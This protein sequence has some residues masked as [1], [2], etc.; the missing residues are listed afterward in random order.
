MNVLLGQETSQRFVDPFEAPGHKN[1]ENLIFTLENIYCDT[2]NFDTFVSDYPVFPTSSTVCVLQNLVSNHIIPVFPDVPMCTSITVFEDLL[3]KHFHFFTVE[4]FITRDDE[5]LTQAIFD[6]EC[7]CREHWK[8]IN[9]Y[10]VRAAINHL[11][12]L[13]YS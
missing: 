11:K 10:D 5:H 3:L 1:I 7:D 2:K 8:L 4:E 6:F 9:H 12:K 13:V